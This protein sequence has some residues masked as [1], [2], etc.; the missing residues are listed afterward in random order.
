M[1]IMVIEMKKV[2]EEQSR[3][4][5]KGRPPGS[6]NH[7]PAQSGQKRTD[8]K[9]QAERKNKLRRQR[10]LVAKIAKISDVQEVER[11][12]NDDGNAAMTSNI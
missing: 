12:L 10:R 8:T 1:K 3:G 4:K 6:K 5:K 9:E 2:R 11:M 7:I